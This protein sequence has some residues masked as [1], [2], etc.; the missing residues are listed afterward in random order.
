MAKNILVART[1]TKQIAAAKMVAA[2][3]PH[4]R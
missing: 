1:Q 4:I 2:T 3:P